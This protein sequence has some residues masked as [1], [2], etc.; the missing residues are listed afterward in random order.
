[1]IVRHVTYP[2]DTLFGNLRDNWSY[3]GVVFIVNPFQVYRIEQPLT[4]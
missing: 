4:Y 1:M 2:L 3:L